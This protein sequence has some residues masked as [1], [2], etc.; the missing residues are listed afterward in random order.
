VVE[1][2]DK[3]WPDQDDSRYQDG[4]QGGYD[5]GKADGFSEGF[6][7]AQQRRND[8]THELLAKYGTE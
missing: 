4:Y 1:L 2:A 8:A 3:D 6:A 7:A 5:K